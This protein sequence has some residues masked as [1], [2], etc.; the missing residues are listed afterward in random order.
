MPFH[1]ADRV[2]SNRLGP[3]PQNS[4]GFGSGGC[5][6]QGQGTEH[7]RPDS[8]LFSVTSR[9]GRGRGALRG[10]LCEGSRPQHQGPVPGAPH[11]SP[12]HGRWVSAQLWVGAD[13]QAAAGPSVPGRARPSLNRRP[14]RPGS[15]QQRRLRTGP[16]GRF[17]QQRGVVTSL[18]V[19]RWTWPRETG[20]VWS[21]R[22]PGGLTR[23]QRCD[24]H[25][26]DP[27]GPVTGR[28]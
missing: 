24:V 16:C 6:V 18:G 5:E 19:G 23:W 2:L 13:S 26:P 17:W 10:A 25:A 15:I 9:A 20:N 7:S 14:E 11:P 12:S 4:F 27:G 21:G 28:P 22:V 8:R 1:C 3:L